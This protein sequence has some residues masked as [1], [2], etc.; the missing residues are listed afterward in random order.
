MDYYL[1][2]IIYR[3]VFRVTYRNLTVFKFVLQFILR[4]KSSLKIFIE[5]SLFP[6]PDVVASWY[7]N[8]VIL[9][10]GTNLFYAFRIFDPKDYIN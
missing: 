6:Q 10:L 7:L 8:K 4:L 9:H 2:Y 3:L 5:S 1:F